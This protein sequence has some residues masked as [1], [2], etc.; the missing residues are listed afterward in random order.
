[1]YE[2]AGNTETMLPP[3]DL[4]IGPEGEVIDLEQEVSRAEFVYL[5]AK[6]FEL[7]G[8][9]HLELPFTDADR[10][11]SSV[12]DAVGAAVQEG[13]AAGWSD[14]SFRPDQPITR[15]EL[16]AMLVKALQWPIIEAT[17]DNLTGF[18]QV[19][20]WAESY[21]ATASVHQLFTAGEDDRLA[22]NEP[23]TGAET[24]LLLLQ[25]LKLK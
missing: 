16:T 6:A 15:A 24:M 18:D 4:F 5:L 23:V 12:R 20:K 17:A 14:G 13:I 10:I 1:M 19:P 2:E 21:A 9:V 11:D 8:D 3:L 7:Q 25:S 22:F